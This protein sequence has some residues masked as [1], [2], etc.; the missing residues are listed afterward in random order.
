MKETVSSVEMPN[1][2]VQLLSQP[3]EVIGNSNGGAHRKLTQESLE[4][5]CHRWAPEDPS[6]WRYLKRK[7]RSIFR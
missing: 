4:Q 7:V 1:G 5:W 6:L 3:I 2:I